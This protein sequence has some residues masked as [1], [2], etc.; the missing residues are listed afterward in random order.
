LGTIKVD[1]IFLIIYCVSYVSLVFLVLSQ[2][3]L[4]RTQKEIIFRYKNWADE[5]I[6]VKSNEEYQAV[7]G[8]IKKQQEMK[9]DTGF[10]EFLLDQAATWEKKHGLLVSAND[11]NVTYLKD[12]KKNGR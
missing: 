8:E 1:Y 6:A 12:H 4:I 9:D 2:M 3:G 5:M 10:L 11:D 7:L